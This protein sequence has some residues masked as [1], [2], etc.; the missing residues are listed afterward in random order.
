[1]NIT[2]ED[3]A[4]FTDIITKATAPILDAV[5]ALQK[6]P[7]LETR[8]EEPEKPREPKPLKL[9]E[10]PYI[11]VGQLLET[12]RVFRARV[13][14]CDRVL[15]K[16]RDHPQDSS[17]AERAIANARGDVKVAEEGFL[18]LCRELADGKRTI[19]LVADSE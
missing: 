13:R 1:V 14:T 12:L 4:I 19:A 15:E 3:R 6:A 8:K 18:A 5:K 2:L 17:N 9:P 11:T 7:V 10:G 16:F